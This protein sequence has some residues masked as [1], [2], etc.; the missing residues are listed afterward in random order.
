M[1]DDGLRALHDELHASG[2]RTLVAAFVDLHG[3]PKGKL[4]P[5]ERL[6]EWAAGAERHT[7]YSM[8]GFGSWQET[9]EVTALP[10][11][12]RLIRLPWEPDRAWAPADLAVEG[13][14]FP[15]STRFVLK[16]VLAEAEAMGFAC[17]LGIECEVSLLRR[18]A[19]GGLELPQPGGVEWPCY[20]LGGLRAG[21]T[22]L[23]RV[24]GAIRNLGW[25]LE[26]V[27]HEAGQ[28]QFEFN[29]RYSDALTTCDRLILFRTMIKHY[30]EDEGLVA[31]TMP[32]PFADGSGN[33]AHFNLS[34][35]RLDTGANAFAGSVGEDSHG[36]GLS[37]TGLHFLGGVL[38]HGRGL[39]AAFAPTVNSY[40]RM[41]SVN[42]TSVVGPA[43]TF[44]SY[45]GNVRLNALRV[46][47]GGG[48]LENR[49]PDGAVNPYLAAAL[50]L[51]AGLEGIRERIDPG[52]PNADDLATLD[53]A[54][55]RRRGI[56]PLPQTLREA[57][58]A[59]AANPL[60]GRTLGPGL[61]EAF[62]QAKGRE[63]AEYHHAVGAWETARYS[64]MF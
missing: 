51:A 25:G 6:S 53:P 61:R 28:S 62:V 43:P 56:G 54:E 27:S 11:L 42:G 23:E 64:R 38:R 46:P 18:G 40:K 3:L 24:A 45:G 26:A 17:D 33:G 59:F 57:V 20:D 16:T 35:R 22:W 63:W 14:P 58:E 29:I 5:L 15:M 7:A 8:E 30:A 9:D 52:P 13:K 31:T 12:S 10:D 44:N 2:V 19:D 4:V 41:S 49:I 50:M 39:C 48:R 60:V 55:R 1:T 32:K 34:L 36:L 21:R 47:T 37:E